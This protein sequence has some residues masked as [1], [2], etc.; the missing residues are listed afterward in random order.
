MFY[1]LQFTR[2]TDPDVFIQ[3]S[4]DSSKSVHFPDT[5]LNRVRFH[6]KKPQVLL[7]IADY[8]LV[9]NIGTGLDDKQILSIDKFQKIGIHQEP[10]TALTITDHVTGFFMSPRLTAM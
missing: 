4:P 7:I 6:W 8:I 10:I 5:S 1:V 3:P 9:W 2:A